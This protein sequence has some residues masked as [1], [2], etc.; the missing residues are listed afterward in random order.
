MDLKDDRDRLIAGLEML[1]QVRHVTGNVQ[2]HFR[3]Q[4]RFVDAIL[5]GA[6]VRDIETCEAIAAGT[7]KPKESS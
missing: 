2:P 1:A 6:D 4:L 5:K 3:M 7:W